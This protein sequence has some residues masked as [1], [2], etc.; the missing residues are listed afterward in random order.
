MR[1][2]LS[3]GRDQFASLA[4][5]L[6]R[7]LERCGHEVWF[8]LDRLKPGGDWERYIEDGFEFVSQDAKQGRFVV[9][10]TEHSVRRPNGYC[11]NELARA[12]DRNLA[13]VPVLVSRV[14]PP[15]SICRIQWL[16]M[17]DCFPAED[18]E[19]KYH[20]H[21][22][23]LRDAIEHNNLDFQGVQAR[24]LNYLEPLSYEADVSRHLARFTGRQWVL[25]EVKEWLSSPR[26]ALWITGEAGVG[27]SALAAW[28]SDCVGEIAAM[29]YCRYGFSERVDPRRALLSLAYQLS[30]QLHDYEERLNASRLDTLA[31][32]TDARTIFDKLF[33]GPLGDHFPA[34]A[35]PAVLLLDALDEATQKGV[36]E[37]ASLIGAEF[38]RTPP[39]L[40]L[41]VT[42][43]PHEPEINFALQSLDPWKLEADRSE[44]LEDIRAY[45]RRE[46]RRFAGNGEPRPGVVE[47]ISAKS[48]G[49]F[50]YVHWV[51]EE[52]QAGRL[53]LDRVDEFPRGLGGIYAQFFERR[54][55]DANEYA[56][57]RR[58]LLEV[59]CAAREPM[60]RDDLAAVFDWSAYQA[61]D[62]V[63]RLGSLFPIRDGRP[64]PF[65]QS[66]RD[67]LT[68]QDQA[69]PYYVRAEGAIGGWRTS[70]RVSTS[71]VPL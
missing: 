8:D 69:G 65:H 67:W 1:I 40:R 26:R 70:D 17:R 60:A 3:Y 5:R 21:F 55:P 45:L 51:R 37:L 61:R 68:N 9:L 19:E 34:P 53:S 33:V 4:V 71:A 27:K 49:S 16:D 63:G 10:L 28:L 64:R 48:K 2:F 56:S 44:N 42:S 43:R 50:L 58:P 6:K 25:K 54:F 29:H 46:L 32:A 20:K 52:L 31:G 36:N 57:Q 22:A 23:Q 59:I 38:A 66:V 12:C 41:I 14:E 7:D 13:I 39:W 15:L 11:L 35:Q 18:H 47:A 62:A 24:L 30:T